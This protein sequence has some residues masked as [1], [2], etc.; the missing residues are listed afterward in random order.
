VIG[1]QRGEAL[2]G[3][4]MMFALS[5]A[6]ARQRRTSR[7][8]P[9]PRE[10]YVRPG[11]G[12][13]S[14]PRPAWFGDLPDQPTAYVSLG[15]VFNTLYPEVF[16]HILTALRNEPINLIMTVGANVDPTRFGSQP[17][18]VRIERY[19][20]QSELLPYID[21][22]INHGGYNTVIEPLLYGIPQ[23]VLPLAA[24]QPVLALLCMAHG[25]APTLPAR[26][27]DLIAGGPGLPIVN[28]AK[29]TP[30]LIRDAVRRVLAEPT[31]RAGAQA[32]QAQLM[33]LPDLECAVDRLAALAGQRERVLA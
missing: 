5:L 7:W 14:S 31:Y 22:C 2:K 33:A 8:Q 13:S 10:L 25:I 18:N 27:L 30:S 26:A 3:M 16:E 12:V 11:A 17:P 32:M 4:L 21:V 28:P 24:D 1:S 29:M 9:N 15:T 20:P 19:I 6:E 23:V